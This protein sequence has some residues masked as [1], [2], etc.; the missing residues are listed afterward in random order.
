M[1]TLS[2]ISLLI[3]ATIFSASTITLAGD[4]NIKNKAA[5]KEM[6][7]LKKLELQLAADYLDDQLEFTVPEII[8]EKTIRVYDASGKLIMDK[9]ASDPE[10]KKMLLTAEFLIEDQGVTVYLLK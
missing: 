2:K 4:R 7:A 1:K 5:A 6:A 9:A 10:A 8:I 3:A